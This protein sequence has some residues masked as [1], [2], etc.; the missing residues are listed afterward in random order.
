MASPVDW[1][2]YERES[3]PLVQDLFPFGERHPLVCVCVLQVL[4]CSQQTRSF[5][6]NTRAVGYPSNQDTREVKAKVESKVDSQ[7][8]RKLKRKLKRGERLKLKA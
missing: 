6:K 7:L 4:G 8:D 5:S 2:G 1:Y 3:N